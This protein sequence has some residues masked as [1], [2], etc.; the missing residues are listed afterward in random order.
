MTTRVFLAVCTA[1][2]LLSG[3]GREQRLSTDSPRALAAYTEGV[4]L[5]EKFYYPEATEAFKRALSAD[6]TF[7]MAWARLAILSFGA[8]DEAG[9]HTRIGE[10]LRLGARASEREQLFIRMWDRRIHFANAEAERL[11][12][13]LLVLSPTDPE[14]LVFKGGMLELQRKFDAAIEVYTRATQADTS[15]APAVMLLGYAYSGVND[16]ERALAQMERYIRLVPGAADPRASYADLLL[17]VGRYDEALEQYRQS[18]TLKPDYWYSIN[19]IGTIYSILGRLKDADRQFTEGYRLL[20]AGTTSESA[21]LTTQAGLAFARADYPGAVSLYSS[22]LERDTGS[23]SAAI[24][25]AYTFAKSGKFSHSHSVIDQIETELQR[26]NLMGTQVSLNFHLMKAYLAME[27]G[28]LDQ[29]QEECELALD[30]SSPQAR[31]AVYRVLAETHL[32]RRAF[33]DALDACSEALS[34]NPNWPNAL[35][36]LTRIYRARGDSL[37]TREIG[38]RLLAFWKDADPDFQ[39]RLELKRLLAGS[40]PTL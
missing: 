9:A 33:D 30:G 3:C 8:D 10:A 20:A 19:Q 38:N 29:A 7:A 34:I 13:S 16:Q 12:D 25:L 35:L 31:P 37:M 22:A 40:S 11:V 5:W 18:L 21:L 39:D 14:A 1:V 36:T 26:R 2:L 28:N 15:Y 32:R 23:L 17:R 27:E 4:S 24:G 6:S